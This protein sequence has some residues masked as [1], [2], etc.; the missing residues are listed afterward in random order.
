M[1]KNIGVFIDVSN[2]YYCVLNKHEGRKLDYKKLWA[3]L[4]ELGEIKTAY[5]YGAQVG[6]EAVRFIHRLEQ[7]G[8][9]TKY[10]T[11]KTYPDNKKKANWDVGIAVDI[12]TMM[13]RLDLIVIGSGD[14]DM[15]PIVDYCRTK[16]RD[17]L[18]IGSILSKELKEKATRWVEIP[19]SLLEETEDERQRKQE[20]SKKPD[21]VSQELGVDIRKTE[22]KEAEVK[23]KE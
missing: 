7:I 1:P 23:C 10:K 20:Q 22:G 11:P 18:V 21:G 16:G 2:L 5:A 8:F 15:C 6:K 13:D 17:V 4:S 3:Y 14:G 9:S 12:I 19:E